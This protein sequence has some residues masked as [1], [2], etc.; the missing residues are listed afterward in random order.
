MRKEKHLLSETAEWMTNSE[1]V[2]KSG[3]ITRSL[4]EAKIVIEEGVIINESWTCIEGRRESNFYKIRKES[5]LKYYFE[6]VSSSLGKHT[7]D[8]NIDRNVLF[9]KFTVSETT[10]NGYETIV[11]DQDECIVYGTLY[12]G[13]EL[14]NSW[15]TIMVKMQ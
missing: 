12:D 8:F 11:T 9:S 2:D 10:L 14:V 1:F 5:D 6:C 3:N 4:G 13:K 15:R 7:G